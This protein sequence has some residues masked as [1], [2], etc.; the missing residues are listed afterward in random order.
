MT[1][2]LT[3]Q[4]R[5]EL[6]L[7]KTTE[8]DLEKRTWSIPEEHAKQGR[9]HVLPLSDWAVEEIRSLMGM[10][11]ASLY[12]LPRKDGLKPINPMLITHSVERLAH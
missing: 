10:S 7:A 1:V 6:A 9:D 4:R 2:L 3:M 5:Q 11:S 12:L 8:F